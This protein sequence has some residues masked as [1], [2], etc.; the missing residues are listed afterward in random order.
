M[1]GEQAALESAKR[2][3]SSEHGLYIDG[4]WRGAAS[5]ETFAT[6]NPADGVLLGHAASAGDADV[7]AAVAA[8]RAAM[9]GPWSEMKPS[10]RSRLIN[11]LADALENALDELA[12]LETLDNGKP[13]RDARSFDIPHAIEALRYNA[14]WC[15]KLNGES[16]NLSGPGNWHAY[17]VREPVGVVAAIVP[18]NAPL[19]MA[20]A[21]VAPALAAGC[22]VILKPAELTPLT[23]LRLA[24]LVEEVGFPKGV[25]NLLTG[26]GPTAGAALARHP[27]ID[28]ISFTGST[29]VGR[30]I[31][32][33]AAGNFKRVTLELGGKTPTIILPD[34]DIDKAI[35]GAAI[36]I[37]ANAGQICNA[38]SRLFAHKSVFERVVEG[39]AE[40]ASAL[41]LGSGLD[42]ETNMGPLIS[43][44]QKNRVEGY[45]QAGVAAGAKIHK[46]GN[47]GPNGGHFVPP[48]VLT[49]TTPDMSVVREEIFGAGA[50]RHV[51]R[52][53]RSR[54]HRDRS[55]CQRLWV[56]R[57]DLDQG[58]QR[59]ASPGP[60]AQGG[61]GAGQWRRA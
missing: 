19:A 11:R 24:K 36:S 35:A 58:S 49:Q 37:F 9:A 28:K 52:R 60:Q 46:Q 4:A 57:G 26:L 42:P 29:A 16:I 23:A 47:A 15:T 7:D 14:G 30:D 6:H 54:R 10:Q 41:K 61:H 33:A 13:L 53:K 18:W 32:Q 48:T 56:G 5:G 2:F 45:I 51:F 34:A 38:G 3:A 59:R 22:T 8:A 40:R 31:I 27:G 55:E 39:I 20:V 25:F 1:S 12:L 43:E 44:R 50:V 17:T 21:K